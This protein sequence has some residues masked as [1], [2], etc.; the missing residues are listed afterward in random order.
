MRGAL[1][2][3]KASFRV[4]PSTATTLP[5]TLSTS[6]EGFL[7]QDLCSPNP[8]QM[9]HGHHRRVA[10]RPSLDTCSSCVVKAHA[11]G[12]ETSWDHCAAAQRGKRAA[13]A[14]LARTPRG[15]A[16]QGWDLGLSPCP[17]PM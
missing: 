12:W 10:N 7:F 9:E 1:R 11:Q 16:T 13:K 17:A 5:G 8:K 2:D 15:M 3:V 6:H 4:F 14:N